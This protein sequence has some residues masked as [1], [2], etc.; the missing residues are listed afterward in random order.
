MLLAALK[1]QGR[2][3][4]RH[5]RFEHRWALQARQGA[6]KRGASCILLC[7]GTSV[8]LRLGCTGKVWECWFSGVSGLCQELVLT[9]PLVWLCFLAAPKE[10]GISNA[11]CWLAPACP[12]PWSHPSLFKVTTSLKALRGLGDSTFSVIACVLNIW[13]P[14]LC[15]SSFPSVPFKNP[16]HVLV[17]CWPLLDLVTPVQ[18]SSGF[19][20]SAPKP[21]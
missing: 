4:T 20:C 19:L 12:W 16:L 15:E 9:Q 17:F 13:D 1:H 8:G 7:S 11:A 10:Q 14:C 2:E 21:H 5:G 6:G 3:E 18:G